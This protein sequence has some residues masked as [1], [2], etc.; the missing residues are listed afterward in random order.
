MKRSIRGRR[1][2]LPPPRLLVIIFP[3]SQLLISSL[4]P[5]YPTPP[6]LSLWLKKYIA[7]SHAVSLFPRSARKQRAGGWPFQS[8]RRQT[9][10]SEPEASASLYAKSS[11]SEHLGMSRLWRGSWLANGRAAQAGFCLRRTL[12]RPRLKAL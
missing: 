7:R 9:R 6:P 8:L 12:A 3:S 11:L 2:I 1:K 4:S 10:E 5:T